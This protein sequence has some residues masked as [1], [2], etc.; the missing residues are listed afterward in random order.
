M[1]LKIVE[2]PISTAISETTVLTSTATMTTTIAPEV[3]G[4]TTEV[5]A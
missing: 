1:I 2:I 5:I 4:I 3:T